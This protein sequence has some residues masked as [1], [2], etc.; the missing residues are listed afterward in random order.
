METRLK[1]ALIAALTAVVGCSGKMEPSSIED[2]SSD[3]L[4]KEVA[5][6]TPVAQANP[7]P[8][9][10]SDGFTKLIKT[11]NYR[12]EVENVHKASDAIEV[13]IR[14]HNAFLSSSD[15][16]LDNPILE[17]KM[18]IRVPNEQF[19]DLLKEI[20]LEA[21]FVNFRDI[22]TEDVSKQFVDL[23]SRLRSKREVEQRYMEILRKKAGTIEELLKAEEQIG[24]LHEEIEATISRINYLKDEV[25]YSTINLEIYQQVQ[26]A[27]A[28]TDPSTLDEMKNAL[29][30]GWKGLIGVTTAVLY[31]WP[32]IVLGGAG[33][34]IAR[35]VRRKHRVQV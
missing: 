14:R 29:A 4:A 2:A 1:F 33:L 8:D 24:D 21:R 16:R 12:F 30:S 7:V 34:L 35:L 32:L 26:Q 9:L 3:A 20:D 27:V 31:L 22:K 23:E 17:S 25:R 5:Q 11:A 19:N 18:T 10:Y 6:A 15:L 28:G 13:A